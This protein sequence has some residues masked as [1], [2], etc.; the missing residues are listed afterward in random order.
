MNCAGIQRQSELIADFEDGKMG[1]PANA[2]GAAAGKIEARRPRFDNH[3]AAAA[4]DRPW[5]AVRNVDAHGA[6]NR[7]SGSINNSD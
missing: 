3:V 2:D 4:Q 6:G 1:G 7:N 5:K